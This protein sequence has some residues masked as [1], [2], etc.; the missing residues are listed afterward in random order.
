MTEHLQILEFVL[1]QVIRYTIF[2]WVENTA[3]LKKR[4]EFIRHLM[5]I[6]VKKT[7]G[8]GIFDDEEEQ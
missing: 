7:K 6:W 4:F 5:S 3:M 1:A 8:G 2:V